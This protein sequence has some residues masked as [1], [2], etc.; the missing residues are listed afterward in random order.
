MRTHSQIDLFAGLDEDVI[1]ELR[2]MMIRMV[3][4]T[5]M[6]THFVALKVC[7]RERVYMCVCVCGDSYGFAYLY[8]DSFYGAQG[9]CV[10]VWERERVYMCFCVGIRMVLHIDM[11]THFVALKTS[12]C[13][14]VRES[15]CVC[16]CVW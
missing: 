6:S 4:H 9:V 2:D 3:L 1:T 10:L 13:V 14:C 15:I 12:V 8:V 11:S 7:A 16:E 5:D